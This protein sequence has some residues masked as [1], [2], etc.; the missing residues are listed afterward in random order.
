[1]NPRSLADRLQPTDVPQLSPL[2]RAA[3][4]LGRGDQDADDVQRLARRRRVRVGRRRPAQRVLPAE[5]RAGPR[6]VAHAVR[7]RAFQRVRGARTFGCGRGRLVHRG[8]SAEGRLFVTVQ[9]RLLDRMF[10]L[11]LSF[12]PF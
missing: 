11:P 2:S 9:G 8:V 12:L 7:H 1:M 3:R 6:H 4:A 10:S 5:T